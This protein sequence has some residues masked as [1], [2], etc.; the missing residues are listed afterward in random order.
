MG[1]LRRAGHWTGR[2]GLRVLGVVVA[3]G[4]AWPLVRP[5][6]A[7]ADPDVATLAKV[8]G[9]KVGLHQ[10]LA[11]LAD[12]EAIGSEQATAALASLARG[13][14][15]R[16]A[17]AACAQLGR[18]QS[19]GGRSA[20]KAL[21]ED[22]G[23]SMEGRMAAAAALASHSNDVEEDLDYLAEQAEGSQR[24]SSF[25]AVLRQKRGE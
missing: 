2:H 5:L 4:V 25:V 22:T 7:E 10:R 24:L 21:V 14:D 23:L 20:L 6:P 18:L 8:A 15:L 13:K 3:A 16:V 9:S 11:A 17:A 19:S 1:I 12:L